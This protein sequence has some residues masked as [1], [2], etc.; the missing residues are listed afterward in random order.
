GGVDCFLAS[1][2]VGVSGQVIGVDMTPEMIEKAKALAV[3][4]NYTNVK[5]LLGE[6]EN[7]PLAD[8]HVDVAISNCVFNLSTDKPRAFAEAYRVL[9]P[10]GRIAFS[11]IVALAQLPEQLRQGMAQHVGCMAGAAQISDIKTMLHTA[12]FERIQIEPRLESIAF[13]RKLA[14]GTGIENYV[15]SAN[16]AAVKPLN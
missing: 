15:V 10:G 5:F 14:P 4:A 11:D 9:K 6:I 8:N 16:I 12:G 13:I 3:K 2:K 7:L 1:S